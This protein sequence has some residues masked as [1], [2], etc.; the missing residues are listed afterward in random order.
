MLYYVYVMIAKNVFFFLQPALFQM[1]AMMF[2]F[3]Y[4]FFTLH[5]K[6]MTSGLNTQPMLGSCSLE[7]FRG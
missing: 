4:L 7:H 1:G 6:T 5:V 3:I 2:S